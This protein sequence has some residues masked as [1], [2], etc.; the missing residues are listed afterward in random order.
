ME[1]LTCRM[2]AI[3]MQVNAA[4]RLRVAYYWSKN[5][6]LSISGGNTP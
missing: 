4:G 6:L 1:L 2:Q 3:N 5:T